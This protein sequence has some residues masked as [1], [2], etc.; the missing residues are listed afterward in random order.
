VAGPSTETDGW[1][2]SLRI[3]PTRTISSFPGAAQERLGAPDSASPNAMQRGRSHLATSELRRA[4]APPAAEQSWSEAGG[5]KIVSLGDLL[6]AAF[7]SQGVLEL[8]GELS[9]E[10]GM[11]TRP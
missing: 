5:P 9:A 4:R 11:W 2:Q 10:T 6:E 1:P 7:E 8:H 3:S